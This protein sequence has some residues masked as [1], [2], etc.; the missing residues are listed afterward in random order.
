MAD[1]LL[2]LVI[3]G[4]KTATSWAAVHGPLSSE[5]GKKQLI[6]DSQGRPRAIVETLEFSLRKFNEVDE[7]FARDEGEGDL[8]LA[9]WRK[10]HKRYFTQEGTFSPSM[11]LY[12]QRFKLIEIIPV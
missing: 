4:R 6:K 3:Q 2:E 8:S 10:E 9:Y 5:T 7:A 12:C 1:E 11:Q